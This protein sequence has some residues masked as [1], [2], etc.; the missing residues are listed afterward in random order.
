MGSNCRDRQGA[1]TS[2]FRTTFLSFRTSNKTSASVQSRLN[3][4]NSEP[5]QPVLFGILRTLP[6]GRGM[7]FGSF[8]SIRTGS[9]GVMLDAISEGN[10]QKSLTTRVVKIE[11]VD[12]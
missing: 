10:L 9:G 4:R 6:D 5:S 2:L 11:H 7:K 12:V 8:L 1:V 3:D